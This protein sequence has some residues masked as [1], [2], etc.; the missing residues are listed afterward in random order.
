MSLGSRLNL[1]LVVGVCVSLCTSCTGPSDSQAAREFLNARPE[2]APP[3]AEAIR[4][5]IVIVGMSPEEAHAAGGPGPYY[6]R[7]DPKWP[8]GT[9]PL[10]ILRAQTKEPDNS[11]IEMRFRNQRQYG[12]ATPVVFTAHIERGRVVRIVRSEQ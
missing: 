9:N 1:L 2:T 12:T 3:I 10:T 5:G 4:N 8:S 6:I 11:V 7:K